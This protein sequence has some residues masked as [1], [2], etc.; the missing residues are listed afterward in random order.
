MSNIKVLVT[1]DGSN[2]SD[3]AVETA[4]E[5]TR[6]F[7]GSLVAVTAVLAPP[8]ATGFEGEDQAVRERLEAISSKAAE[9]GVPCEVVAEHCSHIWEGILECAARHDVD[10]IVMASRGLGSIG[11]LLLG[12]ETQKVLHEADRPVLVVR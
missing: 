6:R 8:P 11:S 2:L 1:T 9:K 10:Y 7:E 4:I 5:L 3:K 12:S